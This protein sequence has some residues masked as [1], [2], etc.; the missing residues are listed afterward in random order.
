MALFNMTAKEW[1]QSNPDK[2]GNI[3]DYATTIQLLVLVNLENHNGDM[4]RE[5]KE[6]SER[7][8]ELNKKAI[9]Q[10]SL[11]SSATLKITK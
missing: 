10:M 8:R 2:T 7:I 1:K 11:L 3:R 4:I 9:D 6:Q 5:G